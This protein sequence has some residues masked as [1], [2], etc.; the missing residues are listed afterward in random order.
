MGTMD[1]EEFRAEVR[2]FFDANYS[3]RD[4][5]ADDERLD[6]IQRTPDGHDAHVEGSRRLQRQLAEAGLSGVNLPVEYGGRGLSSRHA[7]LINEELGRYDAPSLGGL[8]IGLHLAAATLLASGSEA[9]KQRYLPKII[10]ADEQWCQL[11]SEPDAGSDL[12]SL[13]T[14]AV[15]DGDE[16]IIDGQKVWSSFA[17]QAHFGMLL[18]RTD[19]DA[20]KPHSGITMFILPM[21]SAG[22]AVRPLVDIA[23]GRHFNEVFLEGVRV[24][25]DHVLGGVN[26]GWSVSQGTLG[27]ER[28]GYMG[29][30]G[31]GRRRR[32]V[33]R[34]A[35]RAGRLADPVV[36]QRMAK[37]I[38]QEMILEWLRD[39]YAGGNLASGHPGAGSMMK[40]AAGSLEQMSAELVADIAGASGQAW[41][42]CNRDGD[43]L[44]HDLNATRQGRIAGGTHEIQ[45]NLLGERVL[46]LPREPRP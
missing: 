15:H 10:S 23:G 37:V 9:Q 41:D 45:R 31:G 18:A 2:A 30:S 22:V 42:R 11:F 46:G 7:K 44:S 34:A 5:D 28:S 6:T 8:G 12:V 3:L 24:S 38:T 43:I 13:R 33:V 39:R 35:K 27:G 20:A 1:I 21:D 14:R 32:Q 4:P 17:A 36:R 26:D 29:G 40:L 16:W 19:P 25:A